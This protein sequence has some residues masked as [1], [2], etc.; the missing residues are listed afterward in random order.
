MPADTLIQQALDCFRL[1]D[2]AES[3]LRKEML[4]DLRFAAGEQWDPA[5]AD[6]RRADGKP[7]L[8][9]DRLSGPIRQVVNQIRTSRPAIQVNPVDSGTDVQTAQDLQGLI[10]RIE[11]IS[12]AEV[13]YTWAA[14]H[15]VKMGRGFWRV[16]T[17]YVAPTGV[18][19]DSMSPT[20]FEQDIYIRRIKN[21][22]AVYF[23][24]GSQAVDG[25][26]AQWAILVED[27][28]REQYQA[29]FG[30]QTAYGSTLA[31]LS[32][33]E[34]QGIGDAPPNWITEETIRIAEYFY[35]EYEPVTVCLLGDGTVVEKPTKKA[36]MRALDIRAER[37]V[38]KPKIK[39]ALINAM[40]VLDRRD[41]PGSFI[42]VVPVYGEEWV[43]DGQTDY[44]GIVR[45]GIDPQ[46]MINYERSTQVETVA[47]APRSPWLVDAKSIEQYKSMWDTANRR[48]WAY[49]PYDSLAVNGAQVPLPQRMFGEP[50]IQA[51]VLLGQQFEN[52]LRASTGFFDVQGDEQRPEQS[53][54]AILARQ[55]QG[56]VGNS[57]YLA[58]LGRAIKH[59]G[60]IVLDLMPAVYDTPRVMRILDPMEQPKTVA[61]GPTDQIQEQGLHAQA[62]SLFDPR[63]GRY[64]ITISVGREYESARQENVEVLSTA[65]QSNPALWPVIGDLLFEQMDSPIAK[66]VAERLKPKQDD[67]PPELAAQMQQM[68]Q[69]LQ[70][71]Q[72]QI[73]TDAVKQQAETQRLQMKLAAEEQ[74]SQ[75]DAVVKLTDIEARINQAVAQALIAQQVAQQDR[76]HEIGMQA[77][78]HAQAQQGHEQALEQQAAAQQAQQQRAQE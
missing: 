28:T 73:Q 56:E 66:Q 45:M 54:K 71:M 16:V 39:W 36:A 9:I 62:D 21:Q 42:P 64:D 57:H 55:R 72:Q 19:V 13:A 43:I 78:T 5:I 70:Q 40:E 41:W 47:L 23:D 20:D 32:L 24:P 1:A 34:I 3:K 35:T 37:Q 52:D 75:R 30:K 65:L 25:S 27:L 11:N 50:P 46:R 59:T 67:V 53:G 18:V 51:M 76:A 77:F 17:D 6:D 44:R 68:Q 12:D 49:L 29:R 61:V 69:A 22:F 26:D 31:G 15:Q 14:E 4:R 2:D 48:N 74:R 10:R 63:V 38:R 33:V 8:V 58:N 7:T 60:R